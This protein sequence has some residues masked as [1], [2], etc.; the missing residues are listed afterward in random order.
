MQIAGPILNFCNVFL[1]QTVTF[2]EKNIETLKS[3]DIQPAHLKNGPILLKK[4]SKQQIFSI[5]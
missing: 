1:L 2:L 4:N 3:K 5:C